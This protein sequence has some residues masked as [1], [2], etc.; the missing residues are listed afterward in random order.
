MNF[1]IIRNLS[2][3]LAVF[4]LILIYSFSPSSDYVKKTV[5]SLQKNCFG[6]VSLEGE[7]GSVSY[8]EN[9]F[10]AQ[11]TQNKSKVMVFFRD[12]MPE[13]GDNVSISGKANKFSNQCWVFADRVERR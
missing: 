11:L 5:Y 6:P 9:G 2:F 1:A 13:K 4:G 3:I 12:F 7:L 8:S 10:T